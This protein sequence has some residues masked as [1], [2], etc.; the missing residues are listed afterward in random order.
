MNL[1]RWIVCPL[2]ILVCVA[3]DVCT[4]QTSSL[5]ARKR[6]QEEQLR[7]DQRAGEQSR[8]RVAETYARYS[9]TYAPPKEPQTYAVGDLLTV[10]VRES[11]SFEADAKTKSEQEY[12]VE[13]T[14]DAFIKATG[15]GLGSSGF[16]H[17]K[18]NI[19]YSW[20][21]ES[22][23]RGDAQRNDKLTTRITA[24]IIDVKPNGLL[25]L[26]ARSLVEHEDETISVT[27]VGTCRKED[28][29]ADNSVLSTQLADKQINVQ[30]EGFVRD[31][32]KQGW[33][34]KLIDKIRPF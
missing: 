2:L 21:S 31:A 3:S 14:I 18:P 23:N 33:L 12:K 17:G 25:V 30:N 6:D 11:K 1:S 9:W 28:V 26:E 5:G 34:L 10:I 24:T 15:G 19:D 20:E 8:K 29:T 7:P 22:E 4:A 13:S 27:L 32:S 16:R